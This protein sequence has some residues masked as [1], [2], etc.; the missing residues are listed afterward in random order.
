MKQSEANVLPYFEP[1]E[2]SDNSYTLA[3]AWLDGCG[4]VRDWGCGFGYARRFFK[5]SAYEGIDALNTCADRVADLELFKEQSD[6]ILIHYVLEHNY[7]WE[8]ILCNAMKQFSK[9]MVVIITIPLSEDD[10]THHLP[11]P[12]NWMLLSIP[13]SKLLSIFG[14]TL[15][16]QETRTRI[17]VLP[18]HSIE[19]IF[20]LEKK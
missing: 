20:Y 9:R 14:K 19:S 6:G 3:A 7:N 13:R 15:H 4:L 17:G 11:T 18:P 16:H 12:E 2:E 8:N 10:I 5:S 1:T